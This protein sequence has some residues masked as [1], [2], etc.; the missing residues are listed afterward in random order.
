VAPLRGRPIYVSFDIDALDSAQ[1][2]ATGTPTP[3]GLGYWQAL[4]LVRQACAASGNVVGADLVE[5][6][7]IAGLHAF[8][9]TA[10]A[11]AYKLLSYALA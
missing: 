11:I 9:Y 5:L 7:P 4:D 2:P 6:A 8:D 10:A 3:G 1:M